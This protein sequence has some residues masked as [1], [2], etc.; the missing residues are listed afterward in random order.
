M[1]ASMPVATERR[2]RSNTT[3]RCSRRRILFLGHSP[4]KGGAELCLDT[5]LRHLTFPKEDVFV[6]LPWEGPLVESATR[7]GYKVDLFPLAW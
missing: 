6:I 7:M 1:T 4:E 2:R 5:L 3:D